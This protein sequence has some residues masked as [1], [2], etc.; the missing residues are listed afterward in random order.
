MAFLGRSGQ[1]ARSTWP[2]GTAPRH[3]KMA[4]PEACTACRAAAVRR[5]LRRAARYRHQ[6]LAQTKTP[7]GNSLQGAV[8][9][10]DHT[11]FSAKKLRG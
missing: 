8:K 10:L 9:I 7:C 3:T 11:G 5:W 2:R 4:A 6:C 1:Q